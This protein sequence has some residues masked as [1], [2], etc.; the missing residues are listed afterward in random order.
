MKHDTESLASKIGWLEARIERLEEASI[1]LQGAE[2]EHC[3][4][5]IKQ[6]SE[7][8]DMLK[9]RLEHIQNF[10]WA[11]G[12]PLEGAEFTVEAMKD[13]FDRVMARWL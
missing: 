5:R 11:I 2:R 6:L 9:A 8:R 12:K 10:G 4:C 7:R 13:A 3:E 1:R